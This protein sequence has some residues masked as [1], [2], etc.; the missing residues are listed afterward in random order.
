MRK[1]GIIAV[2]SLLVV[3]LAAVPALA[4]SPHFAGK[5]SSS[6]DSSGAL[7]VNFKEAGLGNN[8]LVD[9]NLSIAKAE[10]TWACINKGGK[11]PQAANK[12]TFSESLNI[13]FSLSS[14]RNGNISGPVTVSPGT[15][16]PPADFSCPSG[17][18]L[19]LAGVSYTGITLTDLTNNL[20]ASIP[21][22]SR[23]FFA[24]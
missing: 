18:R 7:V 14:D 11:H 19:V 24:V 4:A 2:L 8:Q 22:A 9:Y 23:T 13:P 16:L 10:A 21:N 3:A 20:S 12:E 1:L 15:P 6:V 5:T 17:Q